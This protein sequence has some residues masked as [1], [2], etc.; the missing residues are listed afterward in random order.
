M[1]V[2]FM[3]LSTKTHRRVRS[4]S[5]PIK[6]VVPP[7]A[8]ELSALDLS[9]NETEDTSINVFING[10]NRLNDAFKNSLLVCSYMIY[11]IVRI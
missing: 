2:A 5:S 3:D 8:D 4:A 10:L 6:V 7:P 11:I 1:S 9:C